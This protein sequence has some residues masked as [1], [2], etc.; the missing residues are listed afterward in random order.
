MGV[1]FF[2]FTDFARESPKRLSGTPA[3]DIGEKIPW[4][5][6]RWESNF[7]VKAVWD[8]NDALRF[9]ATFYRFR[10]RESQTIVWDSRARNRSKIAMDRSAW[11][12]SFSVKVVWDSNAL[13]FTATFYR[14]RAQ[15][16]QTIVWDSHARNLKNWPVRPRRRMLRGFRGAPSGNRNM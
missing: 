16:S 14:F 15:E 4:I 12:S 13:R 8:S 6:A 11:D 9:T 7:S 3:R 10:A 2:R 1:Q 5:G